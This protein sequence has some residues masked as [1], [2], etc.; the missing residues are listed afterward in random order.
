[1][2]SILPEPKGSFSVETV[3]FLKTKSV[4]P[5]TPGPSSTIASPSASTTVKRNPLIPDSV[6]LAS[7]RPPQTKLDE[8]KA[9]YLKKEANV[10]IVHRSKNPLPKSSKD[11]DESEEEEAGDFFSLESASKNELDEET[12]EKLKLPPPVFQ[13]KLPEPVWKPEPE[14]NEVIASSSQEDIVS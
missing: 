7:K 12:F 13:E 14:N 10:Q 11:S 4:A 2:F 5:P 9:K 6:R 8:I 3:S 1:L